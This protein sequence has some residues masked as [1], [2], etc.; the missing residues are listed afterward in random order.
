MLSVAPPAVRIS[1]QG[2]KRVELFSNQTLICNV[3]I[4][5][6]VHVP[7]SVEI[8]WDLPSFFGSKGKANFSEISRNGSSYTTMVTISNFTLR[9][10]GNYNCTVSVRP[11]NSSSEGGVSDKIISITAYIHLRTRKS[12]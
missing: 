1:R 7:S 12:Q 8:H 4:I 3:D 6:E 9:D 5:T 10:S 11:V 2:D